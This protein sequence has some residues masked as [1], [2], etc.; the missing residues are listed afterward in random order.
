MIRCQWDSLQKCSNPSSRKRRWSRRVRSGLGVEVEPG[1]GGERKS[2]RQRER[3]S[4]SSGHALRSSWAPTIGV[5]A[6]L[7]SASARP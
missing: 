7:G 6:G 3:H 1:D 5:T 2:K 4:S